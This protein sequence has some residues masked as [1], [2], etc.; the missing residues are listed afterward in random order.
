M[1]SA[2]QIA[3]QSEDQLSLPRFCLLLGY[4][5]LAHQNPPSGSWSLL[6]NLSQPDRGL[7]F[8][9][10]QYLDFRLGVPFAQDFGQ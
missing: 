1:L 9:P 5:G 6:A 3:R 2:P 7:L 10:S 4:L 8:Q